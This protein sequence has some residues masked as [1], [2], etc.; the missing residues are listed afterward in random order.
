MGQERQVLLVERAVEPVLLFELRLHR[1]RNLALGEERA[2]GRQPHHEERQGRDREQRRH[3]QQH[4]P[5]QEGG[6]GRRAATGA[7]ACFQS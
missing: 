6:H 1:R 5:D 2:S 7:A 4:T 3:E